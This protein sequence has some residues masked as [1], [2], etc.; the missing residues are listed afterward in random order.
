MSRERFRSDVLAGLRACPKTLPSRWLYDQL[1]SA[2]FEQ[3][4]T[5]PEYELTRL[6]D[7]ILAAATDAVRA[8]AKDSS[9]LVEYGAGTGR[10]TE[11]LVR[12]LASTLTHYIPLDVDDTTF[13]PLVCRYRERFSALAVKP[14]AFDFTEDVALGGLACPG[15]RLAIM[16]GSTIG[17]LDA[18]H[19]IA[20]LSRMRR[21]MGPGGR[22]IVGVDITR[23]PEILIPAY[24]DS[25]GVTARFNLNVLRRINRE[26]DGEFILDRFRHRVR[27][28]PRAA[29]IEMHLESKTA[30]TVRIGEE[31][32]RFSLGETIHTESSFKYDAA[33]F[34]V[35]AREAGWRLARQWSDAHDRFALF[36]L[37]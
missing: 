36:A 3:I 10:K 15:P 19:A 35:M 1:G 8:F 23:D 26:L 28:N 13:G 21:D 17:N 9:V 7:A 20:L 37:E 4:T 31:S 5:L 33:S 24:D 18:P 29:V 22:A 14:R 16:L 6:E 25:R 12:T 34:S 27:W 2:L 32:F 11:R 30:Q